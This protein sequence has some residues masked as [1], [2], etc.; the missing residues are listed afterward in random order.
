MLDIQEF[1]KIAMSN[2]MVILQSQEGNNEYK[3]TNKELPFYTSC[4]LCGKK[5]YIS[6]DLDFLSKKIVFLNGDVY[7]NTRIC[8]NCTVDFANEVVDLTAEEFGLLNYMCDTDIDSCNNIMLRY[9]IPVSRYD[10]E[11]YEVYLFINS[12]TE[13]CT[14]EKI[15][16]YDNVVAYYE[17]EQP[18]KDKIREFIDI[19]TKIY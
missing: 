14:F 9:A 3:T 15:D 5:M 6:P 16:Q 10:S 18:T 13:K 7:N 2:G 4:E 8:H 19:I 11:D 17:V 12:Y 1:L